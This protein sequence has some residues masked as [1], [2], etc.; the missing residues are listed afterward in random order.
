MRPAAFQNAIGCIITMTLRGLRRRVFGVWRKAAYRLKGQ[1]HAGYCPICESGTEFVM[2]GSWLRDQYRCLRCGSIPRWRAMAAIL[3]ELFPNW[4]QLA[5]HES[6]PGGPLSDKLRQQCEHYVGSHFHQGRLPGSMV[7]GFRCEDLTAQTFSDGSFD[8]VVTSDV[9]E[10]V[11][12]PREGFREIARTLRP[13]GGHLFTV[14][15]YKGKRTRARAVEEDGQVVHVLPPDYHSN[16]VDPKGSLV[17]T[18]WGADLAERIVEWAGT[19]TTVFRTVD[20]RMG[21]DGE[22]LEVLVSRKSAQALPTL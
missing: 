5:I 20:R 8:L 6:S 13:G 16:P 4:R 14:P 2:E 11:M 7:D 10:H 12:H 18:E 9:F 21:L 19:P 22:F 3:H 15:I 17:V 1:S